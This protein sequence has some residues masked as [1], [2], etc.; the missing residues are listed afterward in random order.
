MFD[1]TSSP[2]SLRNTRRPA[3]TRRQTTARFVPQAEVLEDRT[4]PAANVTSSLSSGVLTLTGVD[5]TTAVAVLAGDND[6]DLTIAG[7]ITSVKGGASEFTVTPNGDGQLDGLTTPT[8]FKGVSSIVL[9][10]KLGNDKVTLSP[11]ATAEMKLDLVNFKGGDGDNTLII[12]ALNSPFDTTLGA[13]SITNGDGFDTFK[14]G[15]STTTKISGSLTIK[16]GMGGSDTEFGLAAGD[17]TNIGKISIT[18]GGGFDTIDAAD[19]LGSTSMLVSETVTIKNG[20]GGSSTNFNLTNTFSAGGAISIV[21]GSGA[22]AV[23]FG[24]LGA[25]QVNLL[26]V[27]VSNGSGDSSVD[28]AATTTKLT[29][30]LKV[31]NT[32]GGDTFNLPA[33][34]GSSFAVTGTVTISN[35]SGGS[36]S[37]LEADTILI[38]GAVTITNGDGADSVTIGRNAGTKIDLHN[39]AIRNGSGGSTTTVLPSTTSTITGNL[40]VTNVDGADNITTTGLNVTGTFKISNGNDGSLVNLTSTT[41]GT[42]VTKAG[43]SIVA[44]DGDDSVFLDRVT[45]AG[46]TTVQ[47]GNGDDDFT[48]LDAV[49]AAASL[50][51]GA[52]NDF[53]ALEPPVVNAGPHA[54]TD[55]AQNTTFAGT[56]KVILGTGDDAMIVGLDATDRAAFATTALFDGGVG[57]DILTLTVGGTNFVSTATNTLLFEVVN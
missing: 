8:T 21:N 20:T 49:F 47:L 44:L 28:F 17:I 55:N 38:G 5:F 51:L 10:L 34:A 46:A 56:V 30:S 1:F 27:S 39:V 33:T 13:V 57:L 3:V 41:V 29:G 18:N 25:T 6:N 35:G 42:P 32:A 24:A 19:G 7:P 36:A 54:G 9:V 48:A 2:S 26:N 23:T 45:V 14:I 4:A 31:T 16:N 52:G 43:L 53:V 40:S 12:D 37:S 50:T 11:T 22:D 15:N